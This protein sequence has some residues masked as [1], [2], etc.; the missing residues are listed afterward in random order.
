MNHNKPARILILRS[1]PIDPDPRVEKIAAALDSFGYQVSLLGWDRTAKLPDETRLKVSSA[2]DG[3]ENSVTIY[4]IKLVAPFGHGISNLPNLLR[5]QGKLLGWLRRHRQEFDGIHACD[6]DTILPA[7]LCKWLWRKKVVYDIFDFYADHLRA[8]PKWIKRLIRSTDLWAI[9]Q[10]DGLILADDSR[11]A[12]ISGARP[13]RSAVIYNSPSLDALPEAGAAMGSENAVNNRPGENLRLAYIGLLQ[14]E[15]GLLE[16]L[17][18]LKNHPQWS[19]DLAG[20]GG[21]EEKIRAASE[22]LPNVRWH[23]RVPYD[24]ALQ[25]SRAADVLFATYDPAIPN[26]RYSSPNKV[27]EAMLLGKPIIVARDTNMD[28]IIEATR[29]GIVVQYGDLADLEAALVCLQDDEGLCQELGEN[30]RQ[31]YRSTYS[32]DEMKKRLRKLYGEVFG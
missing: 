25:I 14:V 30:A 28:H 32:W 29:C 13:Q 17:A 23:G 7:L 18:I 11:L 5:W 6:F 20:F 15:R 12:Q 21:D 19:L 16:M 31:A 24:Q 2:A 1:N 27:F 4:R 9:G 3:E 26:H 8:T 22:A 10:A